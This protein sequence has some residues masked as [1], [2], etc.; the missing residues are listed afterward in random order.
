[1]H[2]RWL[3][4]AC[5]HDCVIVLPQN[6]TSD[7]TDLTEQMPV[8]PDADGGDQLFDDGGAA[9][10]LI[11]ETTE[12]E[13]VFDKDQTLPNHENSANPVI[14]CILQWVKD[15]ISLVT[16]KW[17]RISDHKKKLMSNA[18]DGD[19][20]H[21]DSK[22]DMTGMK[23]SDDIKV[24]DIRSPVG[25]F[26]SPDDPGVNVLASGRPLTSN[27]TTRDRTMNNASDGTSRYYVSVRENHQ[28]KDIQ[29]QT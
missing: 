8:A 29:H 22:I 14:K 4:F 24:D 11:Q 9:S 23:S 16:N 2:F 18:L 13:V 20:G 7:T 15:S 26:D 10:L 28:R 12:P 5:L 1:M 27:I 21:F 25:R 17:T 3:K 19:I 6:R